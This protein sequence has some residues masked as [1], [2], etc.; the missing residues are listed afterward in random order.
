M[1][2][3]HRIEGTFLGLSR[4]QT[5][6]ATARAVILPAPLDTDPQAGLDLA[7]GPAAVLAASAGLDPY[8]HELDRETADLHTAKALDFSGADPAAAVKTVA[9]ATERWLKRGKFV[10]VLGGEQTVTLGTT[11]AHLRRGRSFGVLHLSARAN[12]NPDHQGR[13]FGPSC[14]GAR[15]LEAGLSLTGLGWRGLSRAERQAAADPRIQAFFPDK[16]DWGGDW[17][18]LILDRLP[19]PIYLSLDLSVLD[20]GLMP[21]VAHPL[22]GGLTWRELTA[23]L[24]RLF[25]VRRVI[26]ADVVQYRPGPLSRS[27]ALAT[28]WLVHRL[29]G[30]ALPPVAAAPGAGV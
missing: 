26:G 10:L 15:L 25:A 11:L 2:S 14:V 7:P 13:A 18:G 29:M 12:L 30:L 20:P 8:D 3:R 16:L 21:D 24:G 4:D 5:P 1:T 6:W 9:N 22:P 17:I 23:F 28:A 27:T 19:D